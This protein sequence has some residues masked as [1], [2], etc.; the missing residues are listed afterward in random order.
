MVPI[1]W[2]NWC[3]DWTKD[4][5]VEARILMHKMIYVYLVYLNFSLNGWTFNTQITRIFHSLIKS[6]FPYGWDIVVAPW[7]IQIENKLARFL[8]LQACYQMNISLKFYL[9]LFGIRCAE[10]EQTCIL[11]ILLDLIIKPNLGSEL[12]NSIL[13]YLFLS[14]CHRSI[15]LP[16]YNNIL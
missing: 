14:I 15:F 10:I 4:K 6:F 5:I 1:V 7:I 2:Y 8:I 12:K 16:G 13:G 3:F 9:K 11:W